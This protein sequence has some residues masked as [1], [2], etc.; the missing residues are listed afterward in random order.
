MD[1]HAAILQDETR[2]SRKTLEV[3]NANKSAIDTLM[4]P[5]TMDSRRLLVQRNIA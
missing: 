2:Q 1:R 3:S 5:K 4:I